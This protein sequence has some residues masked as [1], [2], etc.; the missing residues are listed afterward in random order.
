[1]KT[2]LLVVA[3]FFTSLAARPDVIYAPQY[4]SGVALS[5][6]GIAA[7]ELAFSQS[8]TISLWGGGGYVFPAGNFIYPAR[9][10]EAAIEIRHY[11]MKNK[12][13]NLNLGLYS[14]YAWMS[15]PEVYNNRIIRRKPV[16]GIVPGVKLTWKRQLAENL[17]AEPYI[18][19]SAPFQHENENRYLNKGIVF[20]VG[21][22]VGLNWVNNRLVIS[23]E[24]H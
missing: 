2:S 7:Y 21:L 24:N 13:G 17:V 8:H 3:L 18:S 4:P 23:R 19:I 11:F 16:T 1:M 10:A 14:G 15:I 9:G 5:L 12:Y 22:R 20:T 6:E